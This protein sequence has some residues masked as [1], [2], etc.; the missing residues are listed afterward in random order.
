MKNNR[1]NAN[2]GFTVIEMLIVLA[3]LSIIVTFAI[4]ALGNSSAIIE[5][6][7]VA[8]QFK[9]ALE[10]ARFDSVKRRPTTCEDMSRVEITAATSFRYLTDL[11]QNGSLNTASEYRVVDFSRSSNVEVFE[12]PAPTFPIIIRF[13]QRGETT[14]GD[15]GAEVTA[16]TPT[17]FCQ[18]GCATPG[19]AN[20]SSV[21]VSPSGTVALL[22]GG[23][24]I[25]TF[26]EPSVTDVASNF[27]INEDLSV[28]TGTPP[29]P[30]PVATPIGG[31]PT[32]TPTP[33]L[34]PTPTPDPAATPTPTPSPT[35]TPRSCN[36]HPAEVP[37]TPPVCECAPPR[38]VQGNGMCK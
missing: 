8:K 12:D 35:P 17:V 1:S 26:T 27:G 25:P 21:Y 29:T 20:A 34:T 7:T 22:V 11:D 3:I 36:I 19:P 24:T 14:S 16:R 18:L 13:N 32:P 23:Q 4:L 28:W 10:R 5:R 33:T 37:G 30:T 9:V 2:G 6:Q 38:F 15:C 31:T